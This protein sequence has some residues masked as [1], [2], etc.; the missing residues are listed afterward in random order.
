MKNEEMHCF[1]LKINEIPGY[2]DIHFNIINKGF[3]FVEP[4]R[5]I[6]NNSLAQIIFQNELKIV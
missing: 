4:L 6:F 3:D 2:N 5:Y 1:F